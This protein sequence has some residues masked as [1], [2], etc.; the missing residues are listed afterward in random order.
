MD[1]TSQVPPSVS[2]IARAGPLRSAPRDA[3]D[4][5]PV[6]CRC[7]VYRLGDGAEGDRMKGYRKPKPLTFTELEASVNAHEGADRS[8]ASSTTKASALLHTGTRPNSVQRKRTRSAQDGA[9][10]ADGRKR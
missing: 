9:R 3:P 7:G 4:G 2:L 6:G 8:D 1:P 10:Q 5:G